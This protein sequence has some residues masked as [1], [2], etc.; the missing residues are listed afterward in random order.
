MATMAVCSMFELSGVAGTVLP[1]LLT[2]V[3]KLISLLRVY[4]VN[5]WSVYH[6]YTSALSSSI[7]GV[8]YIA[9]YDVRYCSFL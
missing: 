3:G 5:V 9:I 7:Y 1:A 4:I 6:K 8:D 2:V